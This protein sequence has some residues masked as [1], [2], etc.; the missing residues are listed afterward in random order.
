MA[1]F[2]NTD[3]DG[4]KLETYSEKVEGELQNI[5]ES[6]QNVHRLLE[7]LDGSWDG[8]ANEAF[9]D[10]MIKDRDTITSVVKN[11]QNLNRVLKEAALGYKKA[12]ENVY[13]VAVRALA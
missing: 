12:D 8:E 10:R 5:S 13:R 6:F 11:C 4:G 1:K 7:Q 2:V 9:M 3:V